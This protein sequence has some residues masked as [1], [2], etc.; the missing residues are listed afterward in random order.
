MSEDVVE[1]DGKYFVHLHQ[2]EKL[3]RLNQV[4]IK[5]LRSYMSASKDLEQE[6]Q[7]ALDRY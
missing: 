5:L 4:L 3:Y 2:Y 1:K 7:D 6:L